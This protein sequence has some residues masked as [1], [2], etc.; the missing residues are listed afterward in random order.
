MLHLDEKEE[1]M[2]REYTRMEYP[3][4]IKLL[5]EYYKFH[6]DIPRLF[7]MPTTHFLNNFHDKK[8]RIEY[9]RIAQ[10][11]DKDNK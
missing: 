5:T 3:Y 7:M 10:I 4:K 8:R 1:Y 2:K 6:Q 11:I 9:F